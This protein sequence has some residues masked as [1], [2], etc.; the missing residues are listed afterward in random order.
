M[1]VSHPLLSRRPARAMP[2]LPLL[3]DAPELCL[4]QGRVH[5]ACGPSRRT[6]A[7]WA[8]AQTQGPV[9]WISLAWEKDRL[10][11]DGVHPLVDP[12][13]LLFVTPRRG[14]DL[15]WT[16]EEVLRSG[17]IALVVA[18]MPDLPGL[19]QIRRMHLAAETGAQTGQHLPTGLLLTPGQGGAPGVET[20]WQMAPRHRKGQDFWQLE[21]LRA[22]TAPRKSWYIGRASQEC[23]PQIK[24]A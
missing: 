7:L 16:V 10:A 14:E 11:S 15:L 22:R 3:A 8:A 2:A 21:R 1:V 17:A 6:L 20:R 4:T 24:T 13:R 23:A 12:A 18:D 9:L 5:E 19:T